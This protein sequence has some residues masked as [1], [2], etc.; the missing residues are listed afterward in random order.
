MTKTASVVPY[1]DLR[2]CRWSSL[3]GQAGVGTTTVAVNLA[4]AMADRGG[5]VLVVDAAE[6]RNDLAEVAGV[7]RGFEYSLADVIAGKC[8]VADAI[9]GGPVGIARFG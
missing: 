4:A 8:D 9:V 5:R 7:G 1:D 6:R 2:A 3:R